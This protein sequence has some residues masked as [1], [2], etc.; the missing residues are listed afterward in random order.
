MPELSKK[1]PWHWDKARQARLFPAIAGIPGALGAQQQRVIDA[2]PAQFDRSRRIVGMLR[3]RTRRELR[4]SRRGAG[5]W[6]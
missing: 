3:D 6:I 4:L 2:D 5:S 1:Q